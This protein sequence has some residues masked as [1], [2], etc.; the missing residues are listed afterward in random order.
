MKLKNLKA[1]NKKLK[2]NDSTKLEALDE[3]QESELD[4]STGDTTM[5]QKPVSRKFQAV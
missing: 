5:D 4:A 3:A 2:F 1:H